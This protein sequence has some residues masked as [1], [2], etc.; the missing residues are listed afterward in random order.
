[1]LSGRFKSKLYE[2]GTST[3]IVDVPD[4]YSYSTV[5]VLQQNPALDQAIIA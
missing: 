1:M 2:S 4:S 5:T 3:I